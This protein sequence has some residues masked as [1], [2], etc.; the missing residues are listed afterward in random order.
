MANN[1]IRSTVNCKNSNKVRAISNL[2]I[3]RAFVILNE[4]QK[5]VVTNREGIEFL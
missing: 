5:I 1:R 2:P 4:E 3:S